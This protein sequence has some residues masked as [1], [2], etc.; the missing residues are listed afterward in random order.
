M[1]WEC[2]L[3]GDRTR[4][5]LIECQSFINSKIDGIK[6]SPNVNS[7]DTES[8]TE[9]T[10]ASLRSVGVVVRGSPPLCGSSRQSDSWWRC[11]SAEVA[12]RCAWCT[13]CS[14]SWSCCPDCAACSC[15]TKDDNAI[16]EPSALVVRCSLVNERTVQHKCVF[17]LVSCLNSFDFLEFLPG[18][19][20]HHH[21]SDDVGCHG[22]WRWRRCR[23][24][25]PWLSA[26]NP[27]ACRGC[28]STPW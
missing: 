8:R 28:D 5:S 17:E 9:E 4:S 26:I 16:L 11:L 1:S 7:L 18:H 12:W 2:F 19:R 6:L 21:F 14:R 22:S 20:N 24:I 3:K 13:G 25:S 15:D 23:W 27:S 10:C